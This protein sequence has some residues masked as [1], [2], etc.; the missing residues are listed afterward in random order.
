MVMY[1]VV[2][3]S[4]GSTG[5]WTWCD[6]YCPMGVEAARSAVGEPSHTGH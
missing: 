6:Y 3:V 4:L 1:L 2:L 5:V